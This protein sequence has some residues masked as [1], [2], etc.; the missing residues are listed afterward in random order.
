MKKILIL[1]S[2][3]MILLVGYFIYDNRV[4]FQN[5]LRDKWGIEIG[6]EEIDEDVARANEAHQRYL[7]AEKKHIR[8]AG[9]GYRYV[10]TERD[11]KNSSLLIKGKLLDE[12]YRALY[13]KIPDTLELEFAADLYFLENSSETP[14]E[15]K[16]R[17]AFHQKSY[18]DTVK[19]N[20]Q[21]EDYPLR[22]MLDRL[23]YEGK[24]EGYR[25]YP[26]KFASSKYIYPY[27]I[28]N[29]KYGNHFSARTSSMYY[30]L[31][32]DIKEVLLDFFNSGEGENFRYPDDQRTY[33]ELIQRRD[34]TGSGKREVAVVLC[35]TKR[36]KMG[37]N[38]EV[39][40]I[41]SYNPDKRKYAML[42]KYFFYEKIN[43]GGY[44]YDPQTGW[45]QQYLGEDEPNQDRF[46]PCIHL[47][48]PNEPERVLIYNKE[49]DQMKEVY[50]TQIQKQYE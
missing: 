15:P 43:I 5:L 12:A 32:F 33:R 36:A 50:M 21:A 9:E 40:L 29:D 35:D 19:I 6:R 37:N 10:G 46:V 49:F 2:I 26:E 11:R 28:F 13:D 27:E 41:V 34:F 24:V 39:L 17:F 31:D 44:Y 14:Y 4:G 18:V 45:F 7:E 23:I 3:V 38:K 22:H 47:K 8:F 42:Y 30:K 1:F 48:V 25:I 16:A 20:P